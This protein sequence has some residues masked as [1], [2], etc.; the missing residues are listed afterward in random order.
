MYRDINLVIEAEHFRN[1]GN[2]H[3]LTGILHR[4]YNSGSAK[5]KHLF[6]TGYQKKLENTI[7]QFITLKG[8]PREMTKEEED[9]VFKKM[10]WKRK[11]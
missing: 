2:S 7:R 9:I 3:W 5:Y 10:G 1:G 11:E 4:Y 6:P 8:V